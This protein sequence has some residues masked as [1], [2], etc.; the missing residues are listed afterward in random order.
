MKYFDEGNVTYL[1][2][3]DFNGKTLKIPGVVIVLIQSLNCGH[4]TSAKQAY[5]DAANSINKVMWATIES[6]SASSKLNELVNDKPGFEGY[7]HYVA[8][9]DG[10]H[11]KTFN[12]GRDVASLERFV[13]SCM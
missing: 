5:S 4:C 6:D 8:Y 11:I 7:P 13:N 10:K 2:E 9:K 12:D 1:E 3:K